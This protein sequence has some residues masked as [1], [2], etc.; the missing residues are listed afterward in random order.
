MTTN[1]WSPVI[2][3]LHIGQLVEFGSGNLGQLIDYLPDEDKFNV[4]DIDSGDVV[5]AATNDVKA[6]TGLQKPGLGGDDKSFDIVIGP[7]TRRDVLAEEMSSSLHEKGFCVMKII[8]ST[9][10]VNKVFDRM[11]SKE[12]DGAFSRLAT[13]VE[14]GYLGKNGQAKVMWLDPDGP[15]SEETDLLTTNDEN[16]TSLAQIL[17]P[18]CLD[19]LGQ[20]V[21]ERT[22]ALVCMSMSE[23]DEDDYENPVATE[24]ILADYYS[25][26]ARSVVK[27][28]HFMGPGDGVSTLTKRSDSKLT[29]IQ[30]EYKISASAGTLL[31]YR[32][33]CFDYMYDIDHAKEALWIQAF[34]MT[35]MPQW[36][37]EKFEDNPL[38]EQI[39]QSGVGQGPPAPPSGPTNC[40]VMAMHE[41]AAGNMVE[42][43]K[44]WAAY[45]SGTDGHWE[46]PILRFEY[47]PYYNEESDN[48]QGWTYVKHFSFQEGIEM[49]DNKIFEISNSEASAMDPQCRQVLEV[50]CVCLFEIGLTKK[51]MD[52]NPMHASVSVGCDKA[53]WLNMDGVPTSVA[54]NNQLAIGAN[55]FNYVFNLKGGSYVCD[56]ACSSSLIATHL[57]KVNMLNHRWDPLD[58]HLACGTNL[59]MTVWSFV[60]SCASHMLSPGGRC[61]TFNATANGYNRG[62]GTAAFLIMAGPH[63]DE[64]I[65]LLRGSQIGQDGRSASLSAPNGPAQEKC[66]WGA[67]R[68]AQMTPPES[69][70]WECHG[71]GTSLGDPIEVGA[72]K[73]V[74]IKMPRLEPLMISTSKSNLGHLEGSAAAIAMVKCILCV[75]K[76]TSAPT[77]HLKTL[78]PHLD[79]AAFDAIFTSE[80]TKYM[81]PMG[82]CQVSSFGVGGTNGHAIMWGKISE[83][84]VDL[85]SKF[86]RKVNESVP[87][88][89]ADGADPATWEVIGMPDPRSKPTDK[90]EVGIEAD[91][92]ITWDKI[93]DD[94]ADEPLPDFYSILG[95]FN[96]WSEERMAEGDVPGLFY[97]EVEVPST[98]T[99]Q[100]RFCVEGD[101]ELSI[102]PA[103]A[104]CGRRTAPM[105]GPAADVDT[106]WE[107]Q[108]AP[109]SAVRV[110]VLSAPGA[111]LSL[112]WIKLK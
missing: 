98:G 33:D 87:Q 55:R 16:M 94:D 41:Q 111:P 34:F 47:L 110:E 49:F 59:T 60:G 6:A 102:G 10:E 53:E 86:I 64:R 71:T 72:V 23:A 43:A 63:E 75:T 40:A 2:N 14:E 24:S 107:L 85:K 48:P 109:L 44:S 1:S 27:L 4:A 101:R 82:H 15:K 25:T 21:T 95:N 76:N 90:Y 80:A 7:R 12:A 92:Q 22:A 58:F 108:A 83:A 79:H 106:F 97:Q 57:G 5:S 19:A 32:E 93:D 54:T 56:T 17:Q 45:T 104:R 81:Y 84:K 11:K 46:M 18:Y 96:D 8:Q 68:E 42:C 51:K 73:K 99:L 39:L 62:D 30:D 89:T 112:S 65:C 29:D 61:F 9:A 36:S 105:Q 26:W 88:I 78:N 69:T 77:V 100:F 67:V 66:I 28:I 70:T 35:Q 74:Q 52:K 13:E 20:L 50:G 31:L 38:L 3:G 103:V 91:G 37:L